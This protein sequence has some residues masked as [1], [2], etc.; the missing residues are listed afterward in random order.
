MA[1]GYTPA[2]EVQ[3]IAERLIEKHHEHLRL[4]RIEYIFVTELVKKGGRLIWGDA[5]K[6]SGLSAWLATPENERSDEPNPFFVLE[7][8]L[9]MWNRLDEKQRL[10]LVDHELSH[11][12]TDDAGKPVMVPHDLEEFTGVVQ[13]HGLWR[14][15]VE[16]FIEAGRQASLFE[17]LEKVTMK[18]GE[19]EADITGWVAKD[20]VTL[21]RSKQA[22]TGQ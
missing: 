2:P 11:F 1:K 20:K 21:M 3:R 7:I 6:V 17:K 12:S 9:P 16:F 5:R 13:R 10:A 22:D 18:I 19:T 14:P 4:V 15:E 8:I